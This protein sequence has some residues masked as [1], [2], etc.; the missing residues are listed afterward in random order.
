M[1]SLTRRLSGE[2]RVAVLSIGM[3]LTKETYG[4]FRSRLCKQQRGC[5]GTGLEALA[6]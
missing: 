3:L 2:T 6:W 5:E 1:N 4:M